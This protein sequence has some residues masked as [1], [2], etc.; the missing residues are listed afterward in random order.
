MRA[1]WSGGR[2]LETWKRLCLIFNHASSWSVLPAF[3]A[4]SLPGSACS[5]VCWQRWWVTGNT[6][7]TLYFPFTCFLCQAMTR[8]WGEL[9]RLHNVQ[10]VR[11]VI[12]QR[13]ERVPLCR[14]RQTI[15]KLPPEVFS[16]FNSS[17]CFTHQIFP[18]S[19]WKNKNKNRK[20]QVRVWKHLA[21]ELWL[22]LCGA[23]QLFGHKCGLQDALPFLR[24][25]KQNVNCRL[26]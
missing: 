11:C 12:Q 2:W 6:I 17:V 3:P 9:Y 23:R 16:F 1:H 19:F 24:G 21:L 25:H 26:H 18:S 15:H 4:L 8:T 5:G 13:V 22:L 7:H 14:G 20:R 10:L